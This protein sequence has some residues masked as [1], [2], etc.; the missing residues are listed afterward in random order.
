M[1]FSFLFFL[2]FNHTLSDP[3]GLA[4]NNHLATVLFTRYVC[5]PV[6]M[7]HSCF[8]TSLL[9]THSSFSSTLAVRSLEIRYRSILSAFAVTGGGS[10]GLDWFGGCWLTIL[11]TSGRSMTD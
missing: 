3:V 8:R 1:N 11:M 5:C 9:V 10:K 7:H 6:T 2:S 4:G